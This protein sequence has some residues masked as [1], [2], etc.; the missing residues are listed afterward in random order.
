MLIYA[1]KMSSK[2][3]QK[4][5]LFAFRSEVSTPNEKAKVQGKQ[6]CMD[7]WENSCTFVKI[8]QIHISKK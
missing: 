3:A 1:L 8:D 6:V 7:G 2:K 4:T 5:R